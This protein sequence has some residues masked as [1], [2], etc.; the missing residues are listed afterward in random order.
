[1]GFSDLGCY[2]SDIPTPN[3]DALAAGGLKYTQFYNTGRCCRSRAALLTG[4]YSHQAGVGNMMENQ[5]QPGYRGHLNDQCVTIAE[6][7]NSAGYFTAMTGK[8]HVGQEQGATQW[9]RGFDRSLKTVAGARRQTVIVSVL[10]SRRQ[11]LPT[12][13]LSSV[14]EEIRRWC[15]TGRSCFAR[16]AKKLGLLGHGLPN[17]GRLSLLGRLI[18]VPDG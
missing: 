18:P 1:M 15:E 17:D 13:T 2:G 4:L 12:F 14:I 7:L 9:G 3:L 10:E 6:V 11:H 8:W 16:W 5:G